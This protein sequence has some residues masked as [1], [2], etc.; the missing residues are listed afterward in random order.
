[1]FLPA[2]TLYFQKIN[3]SVD[4][5]LTTAKMTLRTLSVLKVNYSTEVSHKCGQEQDLT[6]P[7]SSITVIKTGMDKG[8]TYIMLIPP[9][10]WQVSSCNFAGTSLKKRRN[11]KILSNWS[12]VRSPATQAFYLSSKLSTSTV[13]FLHVL[14]FLALSIILTEVDLACNQNVVVAISEATSVS[15]SKCPRK[16]IPSKCLLSRFSHILC[17]HPLIFVR[18]Q[19]C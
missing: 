13:L 3:V 4:A 19:T 7:P 10:W 16:W 14:F 6:Q 18:V 1:M 9:C 17:C 2:P 5:V 12:T 11:R 8:Y 15:P